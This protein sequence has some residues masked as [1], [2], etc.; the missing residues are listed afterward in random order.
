MQKKRIHKGLSPSCSDFILTL[1]RKIVV[2]KTKQNKTTCRVILSLTANLDWLLYWM[3]GSKMCF[4]MEVFKRF[5]WNYLKNFIKQSEWQG[6][7]DW[8]KHYELKQSPWAWFSGFSRAMSKTNYKKC[9]ADY[10]LFMK[11]IL[12]VCI[13]DIV[14]VNNDTKKWRC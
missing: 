10:K 12:I 6:V 8:R 7:L 1:A 9:H 13:D 3:D 5:T 14:I 2:I 11:S 4:F